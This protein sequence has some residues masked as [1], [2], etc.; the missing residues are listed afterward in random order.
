M[1]LLLAIDLG[2]GITHNTRQSGVTL[3][4]HV[5]SWG[6]KVSSLKTLTLRSHQLSLRSWLWQQLLL[7]ICRQFLSMK[8]SPGRTV[9]EL[10]VHHLTE[11]K[12]ASIFSL[13]TVL[14]EV[15]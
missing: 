12:P 3:L 15:E 7:V 8:A 13:E 1:P 5:F 14:Q 6:K 9:S 4:V 10:D 11:P 2:S